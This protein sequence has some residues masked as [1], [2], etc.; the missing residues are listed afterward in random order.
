MAIM[1]TGATGF[2]GRHLVRH[3]VEAGE[4]D[5]VL[6]DAVPNRAAIA[7]VAHK[8]RLVP[9]DIR[10]T[11]AIVDTIRK[12]RIEGIIHLAAFLGTG[13]IRNPIPSINVNLVGTN[14]VFEAARL[15]GVRRV[16]YM[17][18]NAIYPERRTLDGPR[19]DEDDPPG[20]DAT[21]LVYGACK[22][23]N[24]HI[25]RYYM[26]AFGLDPVGIRPTSVF[27]EGRGQR[28]GAPGDHFMV[29]PELAYLGKPVTMPPSEQV[30]D[31]IYV[32]DAAEVF[33]RAYRVEDPAHRV[34]NMAGECRR[35]GEISEHLRA[36]FPE[37]P[38]AV[39]NEPLVM[40]SLLDTGRLRETLDFTPR[41]S[42]EEGIELYIEDVKRRESA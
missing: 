36:L 27:G 20:P 39:S 34:L 33:M 7:D 35:S 18:S 42:V 30:S 22:L 31:W 41:Y 14:N 12:Y 19:F 3:M 15:S 6:M 24:E 2:L 37:A 13:G 9:G 21:N 23:F 17:S 8:V 11:T 29:A 26:E 40:N 16:V 4:T 32:R 10:E 1:I 25:A 28:R 5:L 38:L